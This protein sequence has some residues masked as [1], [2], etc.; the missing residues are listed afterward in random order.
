MPVAP[1]LLAVAD[2]ERSDQSYEV[3]LLRIELNAAPC[4]APHQN[5]GMTRHSN[6]ALGIFQIGIGWFQSK[7]IEDR[8]FD[9]FPS[10]PHQLLTSDISNRTAPHALEFDRD[11]VA[12]VSCIRRRK[13]MPRRQCS[14]PR[15]G[16]NMD[17]SPLVR[18]WGMIFIRFIPYSKVR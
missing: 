16:R 5:T 3:S 18:E 7:C 6:I 10:F 1:H 2:E 14:T 11:V 15:N 13:A 12:T 17:V 4:V 8:H 9:N